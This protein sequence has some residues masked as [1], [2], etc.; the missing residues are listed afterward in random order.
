MARQS[1]ESSR[2]VANIGG[3]FDGKVA[4]TSVTNVESA[5]PLEVVLRNGYVTYFFRPYVDDN[6]VWS[7]WIFSLAAGRTFSG[8]GYGLNKCRGIGFGADSGHNGELAT[9]KVQRCLGLC[10][11]CRS[12]RV[13]VHKNTFVIVGTDRVF[14]MRSLCVDELNHRHQTYDKATWAQR[15]VNAFCTLRCFSHRYSVFYRT[16]PSSYPPPQ[17]I[18]GENAGARP[19]GVPTFLILLA[20]AMGGLFVIQ[21][22]VTRA[23]LWIGHCLPFRVSSFLQEGVDRL[24]LIR[25]G[26]SFEFIHLTFRDYVAGLTD[27]SRTMWHKGVIRR[28]RYEKIA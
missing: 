13:C 15:R 17:Y 27:A 6:V 1:F 3:R 8:S 2:S 10:D 7:I 16:N 11:C 9:T 28:G 19:M 22:Y 4:G 20:F 26:G 23:L 25:H 24:F 21:N 5:C 18:L 14:D 12:L